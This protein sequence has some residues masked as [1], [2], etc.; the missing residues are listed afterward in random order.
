M[1]PDDRFETFASRLAAARQALAAQL[2]WEPAEGRPLGD[3]DPSLEATAKRFI[4]TAETQAEGAALQRLFDAYIEAVNGL[5][6]LAEQSGLTEQLVAEY[7]RSHR[8]N[9]RESGVD[10]ADLSAEATLAMREQVIR[11]ACTDRRRPLGIYARP[12]IA[13][14]LATLIGREASAA[15]GFG[16]HVASARSKRSDRVVL[17]EVDDTSSKSRAYAARWRRRLT[18]LDDTTTK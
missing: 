13:K 5:W 6:L 17:D 1:T 10:R 8:R 15:S 14:A 2:G 4:A 12:G 18:H 3:H 7:A 11:W 9:V 16:H